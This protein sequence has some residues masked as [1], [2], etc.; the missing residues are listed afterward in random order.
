MNFKKLVLFGVAILH[1]FFLSGA[2]TSQQTKPINGEGP[3]LTSQVNDDYFVQNSGGGFYPTIQKA[4]TSTCALAFPGARVVVP[5][6]STL[7]DTIAGVTGGC[8]IVSIVDQRVVPAVA[9]TWNTST[10]HY[11]ATGGG[12]AA[13]SLANPRL[14][15]RSG[16]GHYSDGPFPMDDSVTTPNTVTV[17]KAFAVAPGGS[18]PSEISLPQVGNAPNVVANNF[19]AR[20]RLTSNRRCSAPG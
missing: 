6:S 8:T 19:L 17:H 15:R 11:T 2:L 1:A 14:C 3:V 20:Y 7:S 4:V 5:P 16:N 9:Y 13:E 12:V 18:S 10:S